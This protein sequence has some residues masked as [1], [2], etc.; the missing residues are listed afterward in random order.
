LITYEE[1]W[2]EQED[3]ESLLAPKRPRSSELFWPNNNYGAA[4][5]LKDY[6][7]YP[8]DKPL[9]A[10]VPHGVY[11]SID[12]E[13]PHYEK[14]VKLP[15]VLSFPEYV[16]AAFKRGS[17]KVV[18]PSAAPF[19]YAL[20]R[21]GGLPRYEQRKGLI[22]FPMHSTAKVRVESPLDEIAEG[23]LELPDEYQP[24]TVCAHWYDYS[25]GLHKPFEERGFT[26]VSAGHLSDESFMY[27]L[28]HLMAVHQYAGSN[29]LASNT[30]YSIAAGMPYWIPPE[31]TVSVTPA[32]DFHM[33]SLTERRVAENARIRALFAELPTEIAPE[34]R[35][36]ADYYLG[37]AR[38][39]TPDGLLA[40]LLYA[41]RLA[42]QQQGMRR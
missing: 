33:M 14:D 24:V 20:A 32:E 25:I 7:G 22:F 42:Q 28:I 19:L 2:A 10:I 17:R 39:K 35:E 37:A 4:R 34:Q 6:A 16:D 12:E 26:I 3:L 15:A 27:R 1:V 38:F 40:D 31:A 11:L 8:L 36:A 9:F 13:A 23:L 41:E 30:F 29:A 21:V 5:V 18:I